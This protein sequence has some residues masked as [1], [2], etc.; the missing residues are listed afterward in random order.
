MKNFITAF[1]VLSLI[2]LSAVG[3]A[4]KEWERSSNLSQKTR[5]LVTSSLSDS[6]RA[7]GRTTPFP[8]QCDVL[9]LTASVGPST[10][11]YSEGKTFEEVDILLTSSSPKLYFPLGGYK[12]DSADEIENIERINGY[13]AELIEKVNAACN[14]SE[15]ASQCSYDV[16]YVGSADST[17]F[18]SEVRYNGLYGDIDLEKNSCYVNGVSAKCGIKT[19]AVLNNQQLS[20]LRA[21]SMKNHLGKTNIFSNV[22]ISE[23]HEIY[24]AKE[25]GREHRYA[26]IRISIKRQIA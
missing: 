17:L 13:I 14:G 10:Y 2:S 24:T 6:C 23:A 19:D 16:T 9:G 5:S 3:A 18:K 1:T 12:L 26:Q 22:S 21:E 7:I 4:Q 25:K 20:L 11:M 15:S 8:A